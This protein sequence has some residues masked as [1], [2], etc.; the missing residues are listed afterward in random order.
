MEVLVLFTSLQNIVIVHAG[1]KSTNVT[2]LQNWTYHSTFTSL[3]NYH[4]LFDCLKLRKK[5]MRISKYAT[6]SEL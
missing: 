6:L 1:V 5:I 3:H 2:C 4:S